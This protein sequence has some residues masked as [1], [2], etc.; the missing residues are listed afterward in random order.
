[1]GHPS[2]DGR[3]KKNQF[4]VVS[5]FQFLLIVFAISIYL[6]IVKSF[7][8]EPAAIAPKMMQPR[9]KPTTQRVSAS[10]HL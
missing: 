3:R 7:H 5:Y 10:R 2:L 6:L 8:I 4:A 1:M 9:A